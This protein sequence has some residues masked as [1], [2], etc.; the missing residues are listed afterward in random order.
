MKKAPDLAQVGGPV[1]TT[2][3]A[4]KAQWIAANLKP[5]EIYAGI[6]LGLDGQPD[7]HLI[8]LPGAAEKVTWDQAKTFA[9]NAGGE[10]PT[11]R[12]QALLFSNLQREF[13]PQWYWSGEQHAA[14][15]DSAWGQDFYYGVQGSITKSA[16]LRARAVRRLIIQ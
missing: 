3:A 9:S 12:E 14:N 13:K 7:H 10:L 8:L 6:I 2:A 1:V 11:R 5:G 4:D 15:D 16:Q